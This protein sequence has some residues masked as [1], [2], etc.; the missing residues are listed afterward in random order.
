MD[1]SIAVAVNV[2][3]E[4]GRQV[5]ECLSRIARNLP[6]AAVTIFLNGGDRPD[7]T[8]IAAQHGFRV[9]KGKNLGTNETWHFWWLRML[10]FFHET[11]SEVC[12]KFDPDTMVDAAPKAIPASDYFGSI[13]LSRRYRMPFIQGG[14]TGLSK[15]AVCRLLD[16]G[17]L[18]RERA[19]AVAEPWQGLADDQHLAVFLA[20]L[21]I[22]PAPWPE[23]LSQWKMP[24]TN[25]RDEYAIVHPRYYPAA[26]PARQ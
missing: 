21:G 1:K 25:D 23:C 24:V 20:R 12:F 10:C 3:R 6:T 15:R 4:S 22:G 2:Y 16:S 17:L 5:E 18:V 19:P 26:V 9:F 11:K 14:I 8:W 13:W 7:L